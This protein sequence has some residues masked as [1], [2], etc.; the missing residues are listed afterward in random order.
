MEELN[1]N[2]LNIVKYF[3]YQEYFFMHQKYILKILSK[4]ETTNSILLWIEHHK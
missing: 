4:K 2:S 3:I 1:E